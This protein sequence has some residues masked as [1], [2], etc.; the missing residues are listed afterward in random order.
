[1]K[2]AS[3]GTELFVLNTLASPDEILKVGCPT[4]INPGGSSTAQINVTC[5][6]DDDDEFIA[7]SSTPDPFTF[8]IIFDNES[9]SHKIL[10]DMKD[11]KGTYEWALGLSDDDADPTISAG[12]IEFP[13]DRTGRTFM[14]SVSNVTWTIA[15]G[16]AVR[17]TVTL[18]RTG[19][20]TRYYKTTF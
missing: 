6:D 5:L 20:F 3:K 19:G 16:D 1:M 18:Q 4:A 12:G 11:A 10:E 15:Q 2:L 9:E 7:G 17:G 14:A 13:P 8:D